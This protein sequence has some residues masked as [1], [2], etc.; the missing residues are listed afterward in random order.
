LGWLSGVV[1][2]FLCSLGSLGY[3]VTTGSDAFV[4]AT[5]IC[6][7]V[8][9]FGFVPMLSGVIMLAIA[10]SIR[11][12]H[13]ALPTSLMSVSDELRYLYQTDQRDRQHEL[14]SVR[15][16][17]R[18]STTESEYLRLIDKDSSLHHQAQYHA[19]LILQ[20]GICPDHFRR[21]YELSHTAAQAKVNNAEW[22][23]QASYDRWMLSIG[24]PHKYNTQ[25]LV[26]QQTSVRHACWIH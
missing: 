16:N 24:K 20:H 10:N 3:N 15:F 11:P 1:A 4:A 19:A 18:S 7:Q 8:E 25:W 14:H 6:P 13:K 12:T 21:A 9:L 17:L 26:S 2:D 5:C 22:L 23:S